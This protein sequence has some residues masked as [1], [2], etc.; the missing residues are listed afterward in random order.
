MT[1][2]SKHAMGSYPPILHRLKREKDDHISGVQVNGGNGSQVITPAD[3]FPTRGEPADFVVLHENHSLRS[4]AL[5]PSFKR[6]TIKAGRVVARRK[7]LRWCLRLP[8]AR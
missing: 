4:V 6:T 5:H 2:T 7:K 3:L 8:Q 1:L